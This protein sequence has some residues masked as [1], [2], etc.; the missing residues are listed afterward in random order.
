MPCVISLPACLHSMGENAT[1]PIELRYG[2]ARWL[3]CFS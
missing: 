2:T 3:R 1:Q